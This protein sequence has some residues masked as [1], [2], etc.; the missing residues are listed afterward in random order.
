M[1]FS[2]I[3][4]SVS[5]SEPPDGGASITIIGE[6]NWNNDDTLNGTVII[7]S[8]S[9]YSIDDF[10]RMTAEYLKLNWDDWVDEDP[11]RSYDD[12]RNTQDQLWNAELYKQNFD[13]WNNYYNTDH[14]AVRF[15]SKNFTFS[16]F[17]S[18]CLY[19]VVYK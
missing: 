13:E 1:A 17:C 2:P 11:Y 9:N 6:H 12:F 7:S 19:P 4:S 8:G 10:G 15:S 14:R 16:Q 18:W 3:L 5:A